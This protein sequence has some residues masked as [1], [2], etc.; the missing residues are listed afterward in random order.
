MLAT[1]RHILDRIESSVGTY[2]WSVCYYANAYWFIKYANILLLLMQHLCK[3]CAT[4]REDLPFLMHKFAYINISTVQFLSLSACFDFV[5]QFEKLKTKC[6]VFLGK[7]SQRK[8][9]LTARNQTCLSVKWTSL[10]DFNVSYPALLS[11]WDSLSLYQCPLL[12]KAL[13]FS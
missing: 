13:S 8:F 12:K 10:L 2:V 5:F 7:W 6:V 11:Y 4:H 3:P 9:G 1:V